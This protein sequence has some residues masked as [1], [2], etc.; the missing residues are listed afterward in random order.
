MKKNRK[1]Q[2]KKGKE[3]KK[4]REVKKEKHEKEASVKIR[5]YVNL[6]DPGQ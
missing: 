5:P 2:K 6:I 3:K 1:G 4:E